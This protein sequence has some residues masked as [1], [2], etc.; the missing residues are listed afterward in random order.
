MKRCSKKQDDGCANPPAYFRLPK[1]GDRDPYFQLPKTAYY[2]LAQ[3]GHIRFARIKKPGQSRGTTLVN[4]A[5][6]L[7]YV[8]SLSPQGNA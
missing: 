6:M 2:D 3:A 7:A 8:R 5:E 4:F 1:S